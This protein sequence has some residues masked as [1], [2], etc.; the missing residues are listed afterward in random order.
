[1]EA[2]YFTILWL[3]LPNTD[4]NQPWV[5]MCSSSWTPLPP[6]SPSHPSGSSQCTSPEH[7]DEMVFER[8]RR[9]SD[10]EA[11]KRTSHLWIWIVSIKKS[12]EWEGRTIKSCEE[13]L[14]SNEWSLSYMIDAWIY[15]QTYKIWQYKHLQSYIPA[16]PWILA[17]LHTS[18]ILRKI[19]KQQRFENK[20]QRFQGNMGPQVR[21]RIHWQAGDKHSGK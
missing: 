7:P 12:V 1:M 6:P 3:F 16:L 2:K 21:T 14:G 15:I 18:Y 17:I 5:Y 9:I 4:M 13:N 19:R 11:L 10:L 20:L 8:G